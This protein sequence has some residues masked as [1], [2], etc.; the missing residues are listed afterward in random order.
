VHKGAAVVREAMARLREK[1]IELTIVDYGLG[2]G[3]TRRTMWGGMEVCFV[4]P[5]A[6]DEMANFYASIDVLLA[7]SIWPESFG[8]VSREALSAGLWVIGTDVG[9]LSE[10]IEQG[11]NGA[12]IPARDP[13]ALADAI[14][15]AA[16][17]E[18]TVARAGW[19]AQ[20]G[21]WLKELPKTDN[22]ATLHARYGEFRHV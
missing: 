18:G 12:V 11:V 15:F 20:A 21:I 5:R 1:N 2:K 17:P 13:Q 3:E 7:P 8:L 4:G 22:L 10:P 9:A 16:S 14:D 6:L 19:R